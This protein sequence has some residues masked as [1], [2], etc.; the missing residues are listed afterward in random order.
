MKIKIISAYDEKFKE[1]SNLSFPTLE[2]FSQK[3][4]FD[5]E[6]FLVEGFKKPTPWFKIDALI[7]TIELDQYDYVLWVD[8]DAIILNQNFNIESLINNNKI[9]HIAKD[10][11]NINTGVML[12]KV[13]EESLSLLY[14]IQSMSEKYLNHI[15]WEQAAI[16]ELYKNNVDNI[17]ES[18]EFVEQSTL[19]AYEM[20][21]YHRNIKKGQ[22]NKNSFICHFPALP[23]E[24]RKRLI[25]NYIQP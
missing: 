9:L 25:N 1:I 12:W 21:Y 13:C 10:F 2:K 24:I 16:L 23:I 3:N 14:K 20:V 6:R 5:C 15:W 18:T 8:A 11:N 7:N 19:N 4:K 22:I 17:L